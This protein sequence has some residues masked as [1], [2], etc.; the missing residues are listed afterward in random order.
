M[1]ETIVI[2]KDY[3][4]NIETAVNAINKFFETNYQE[5]NF[6]VLDG[7]SKMDDTIKTIID[8][9]NS[10]E[11]SWITSPENAENAIQE[12]DN[13]S[14]QFVGSVGDDEIYQKLIE[15]N[16]T[17]ADK[18][19]AV[20]SFK[21]LQKITEHFNE[22]SAILNGIYSFE[23]FTIPTKYRSEIEL[24]S[25][26]VDGLNVIDKIMG[27]RKMSIINLDNYVHGIFTND[28]ITLP[29]SLDEETE[30]ARVR[31]YQPLSRD[32]QI[33]VDETI[34]E[35]ADINYFKDAKPKHIKYD[36]KNN[37]FVLS[38]QM[39]KVVDDIVSRLKKCN[40][41]RDLKKYFDSADAVGKGSEK[42]PDMLSEN[43]LPFILAKV[44]SNSNKF[45]DDSIN[46]KQLKKF[47]D[48]YKSINTKNPGSKRFVNYDLFSTFKVDKDGT[49]KF[50][51]DFLTLELV[52]SPNCAISNNGLLSC[53][54]IFDSRIY[55][56]TLYN[57]IPAYDRK[58]KYATEDQ[59]VKFIRARINKASRNSNVYS[60]YAVI[61]IGD[62]KT[63]TVKEVQESLYL[64]MKEFGEMD[65]SEMHLCEHYRTMLYEELDTIDS[66]VFS[67]GISMI[68]IGEEIETILENHDGTI[69]AYMQT[70]VKL[71]DDLGVNVSPVSVPTDIP[72]NPIPD[73]TDSIDDKIGSADDYDNMLGSNA[74]TS[75][76]NVVYNITNNYT[77]NNSYNKNHI[78]KNRKVVN[79]N[80]N[81]S[82]KTT[83]MTNHDQS[84]GKTIKKVTKDSYN[85]NSQYDSNNEIPFN[86]NNNS[87]DHNDTSNYEPSLPDLP[88]DIAVQEFSNGISVGQLFAYLEDGEAG[89]L[90]SSMSSEEPLSSGIGPMKK[91]S[92]DLLTTAMDVDRNT[93]PLQQKLKK[94]VNKGIQFVDAGL[95]PISRAKQWL[96]G[97]VDSIIE[98]N[99]EQVKANIIENPSYRTTLFK[100]G[101]L[102]IKLGLTG[103]LYTINSYIA[104]AYVVVQVSKFADRERL[105]KD[106]QNEFG[107]QIKVM[108]D[109]IE[110][111]SREDTPEANKTRWQLMR[112]VARMEQIVSNTPKS[113]FKTNKTIV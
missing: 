109:Q 4:T 25:T 86:N 91:P 59:F 75:G 103:I 101:R 33:T 44:Y 15:S 73:L 63:K 78:N 69:P 84:T 23:L 51:K 47:T 14:N 100:A 55:L 53:F 70:R 93:L 105:K 8:G 48:S 19:D 104:A 21:M 37:K 82:G 99:E 22:F 11:P 29:D 107:A 56:D 13:A 74:D 80:D 1:A 61:D 62:N 90:T 95:K 36:S 20:V 18:I 102:A 87:E 89:S 83:N 77:Y 45:P 35:A 57:L 64:S 27:G 50:I 43:V 30:K 2:K 97:V 49:I 98:R 79:S 96:A 32:I 72:S 92:S 5:K 7:F 41:V 16:R 42:I 6:P 52:N 39:K 31:S 94:G 85:K 9:L 3:F 81:S 34:Q 24:F 26:P 12:I 28:Q 106:V 67:E 108:N 40:T 113:I 58:D 65:T 68:E 10:I 111:L 88:E 71:S 54:N 17:I 76:K 66:K 60:E 46:S 38:E 112:Q 110:T